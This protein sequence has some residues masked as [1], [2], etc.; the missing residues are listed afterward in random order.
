VLEELPVPVRPRVFLRGNPNQ[1]GD[2]VPRRFLQVLSQGEPAPFEQG[3]GR[4]ELARAIAD[5]NNPLT[6]R[7][8]VNRVWLEHF[9]SALARTPSDFGM[10]SQ[11]PTHPALLDHLAW[12]FMEEGWSLKNLH[13][14]IVLSAAYRQTSL[15]RPDCRAID[16][17][18]T[19]LWKANRRRL[20]FEATRDALLAVAGRLERQL[21]GP[22]VNG[23]AE[24]SS[25][26]RTI[27]SYIDRL[28]LPGVFR[29]FDFPNPD[30]TSPERA[31]T[32]VP[33]QALFFMNAP[34]VLRAANDLL[35]RP[36]VAAQTDDM[37]KIA[38]L[39]RIVFG[40]AATSDEIAWAQDF[41]SQAAQRS[42]AWQQLAQGLLLA[43][44][45]V[46]ID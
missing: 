21:G 9:G 46:F 22:P 16:P 31:M 18:N 26:R 41:L 25:T 44:E 12:T 28:N 7:V 17:D 37:T 15:D 27:Y 6:A 40:R 1:L 30:A 20:D 2:E 3:S 8:L 11:G 29:T 23:V 14:R 39:Y 33:Q 34:L 43:N 36:E 42:A 45:F 19:W 13:R 4:L 35:A 24:P 5:R 38:R 32:T 10:R